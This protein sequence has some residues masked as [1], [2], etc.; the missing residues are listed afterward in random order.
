MITLDRKKDIGRELRSVDFP[1][2]SVILK[3]I[4]AGSMSKMYENERDAGWLW[5]GKGWCFQ[6]PDRR[7]CE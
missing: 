3:D 4:P 1:Y 7:H 2:I 5:G 6:K